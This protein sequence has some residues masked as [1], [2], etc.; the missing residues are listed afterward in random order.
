MYALLC[1]AGRLCGDRRG[2]VIIEFAL[3]LP[4]LFLMLAGML[5]LG[6]FSLEK[7]AML[8]GAREGAQYAIA[9][10]TD[11]TNINATAQNA[12]GRT[13]V[14]ATNTLF[15]ECSSAPGTSVSCST[16]CSGSAVLKKYITVTATASFSSV[17]GSATTTF[18]MNGSNGWVGAWTP[19]TSVTASVTMTL[20]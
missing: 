5:D 2:N 6:R 19:P 9:A 7:S 16:T 15:C 12:S 11:S 17:L 1:F 10:P 14:T 20:P 18:G 3:A 4:I 8:Q 13:D